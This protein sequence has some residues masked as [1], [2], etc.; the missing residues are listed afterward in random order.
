M[1]ALVSMYGWEREEKVSRTRIEDKSWQQKKKYTIYHAYPYVSCG[2]VVYLYL[3][4][5]VYLFPGSN[6]VF[7]RMINRKKSKTSLTNHCT[8]EHGILKSL[9]FLSTF[10]FLPQMLLG[11]NLGQHHPKPASLDNRRPLRNFKNINE[12]Q[13]KKWRKMEFFR[14]VGLRTKRSK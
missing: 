3:C 1:W 8:C 5:Q 7:F 2:P 13:D 6:E 14:E 9:L 4:K 11:R 12:W 10:S